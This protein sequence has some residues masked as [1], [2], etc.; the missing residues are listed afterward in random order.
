MGKILNRKGTIRKRY[1]IEKRLHGERTYVYGKKKH[2]ERRLN[3]KETTRGGDYMRKILYGEVITRG[4]ND[5]GERNNI[6]EGTRWGMELHG[7]E[8]TDKKGKCIQK[9]KEG[10]TRNGERVVTS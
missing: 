9:E 1:Y 2:T 5:I 4:R 3:R 7:E 8:Y 6:G 10:I